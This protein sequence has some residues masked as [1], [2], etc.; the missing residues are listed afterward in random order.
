VETG[1]QVGAVEETTHNSVQSRFAD[2]NGHYYLLVMEGGTRLKVYEIKT[3]QP[4]A[5]LP[6]DAL[7]APPEAWRE[8]STQAMR[9]IG[10]EMRQSQ[11]RAPPQPLG[12]ASRELRHGLRARRSSAFLLR[13]AAIKR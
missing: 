6:W 10:Q 3:W 5:Q 2:R 11:D 12:R 7:R 8:V 13:V 1:Q 9:D 4:V